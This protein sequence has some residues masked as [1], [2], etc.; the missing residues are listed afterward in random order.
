MATKKLPFS[1]DDIKRSLSSGSID[2]AILNNMRGFN[3]GTRN[4]YLPKARTLQGMCFW[5]RPQLNLTKENIGGVRALAP[6]LASGGI[7]TASYIRQMLDPRITSGYRTPSSG[8]T[9]P[10][11]V[12]AFDNKQAFIPIMTNALRTCTGWPDITVKTWTDKPGL[13]KQAYTMVDGGTSICEQTD[14]TASFR[15]SAGEPILNMMHMWAVYMGLVFEGKVS[16]YPDFIAQ[17]ELDYQTRIFRIL[18]DKSGQ[19]VDKIAA[20]GPG[21]PLAV[22]I[23]GGFDYNESTTYNE[24]NENVDIRFKFHGVEYQDP[25]I[26]L[27][28]NATVDLFNP[29][30][31]DRSGMVMIPY[32]L[33]KY[34]NHT[35]YP[36][37][38]LAT[39]E[40]EIWVDRSVMMDNVMRLLRTGLAPEITE[41]AS[42]R[43]LKA[44]QNYGDT[45]IIQ[46][47]DR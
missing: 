28:F 14:I 31:V 6:L 45:G 21:I 24:Q 27:E 42:P 37:I 2:K 26:M 41:M 23:G 25:M 35:G 7:S 10:E 46:P 36:Y 34:F 5:V 4:T 12:A 20:T 17:N 30:M 39:G 1:V 43:L 40:F 33:R 44:A 29:A 18:L 8:S 9:G 32:G 19:Y 38:N 13:Y 11:A 16:P 22:G 3:H 15:N 47:G